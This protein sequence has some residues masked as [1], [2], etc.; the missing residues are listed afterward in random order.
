MNESLNH[1]YIFID[2]SGNLDFTS[3]GTAY[4][5]LSAI[6][7]FSPLHSSNQLHKLKYELLSQ[8]MGGHEYSHFHASEDTQATRN[9]VFKVINSID[10]IR[11]NYVYAHKNS[12]VPEYQNG[13]LYKLLGLRLIERILKE[14]QYSPYNKIIMVFDQILTRKEQSNFQKYVKAVLKKTI[15][16]YAIYFHRTM[17]DYN[18]QIADYTAWAK[19]VSLEREE[20]RPMGELDNI[21]ITEI[22]LDS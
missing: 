16:P 21:P 3:R 6:T 20:H 4:F 10:K 13:T 9:R 15:V 19:Y 5:V 14:Y 1:L 12:V 7:T 17:S 2:E 18:S 8:H 22:N 11:I